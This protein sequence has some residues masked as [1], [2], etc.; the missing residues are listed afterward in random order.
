MSGR[1]GRKIIKAKKHTQIPDFD[2]TI[3]AK[4]LWKYLFDMDWP[5]CFQ[6]VWRDHMRP[7][8]RVSWFG[9]D[10]CGKR[11]VK[12]ELHTLFLENIRTGRARGTSVFYALIHEFLHIRYPTIKHGRNM[13]ARN[14]KLLWE[15]C[16]NWQEN[17]E[18]NDPGYR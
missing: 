10:R 14:H 12:I 4:Q 18:N 7:L 5:G 9:G 11:P 6:V 15:S 1:K 13:R 2:P 8:A 16:Y 17:W 3:P